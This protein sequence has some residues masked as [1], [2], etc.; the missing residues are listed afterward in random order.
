[1]N[2]SK[3]CLKQLKIFSLLFAMSVSRH[4]RLL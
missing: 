1:M 4:W 3:A 2:D